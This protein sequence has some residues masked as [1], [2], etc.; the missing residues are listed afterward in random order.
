MAN[1][2]IFPV[3]NV[4]GDTAMSNLLGMAKT[5]Q[6][7]R[8]GDAFLLAVAAIAGCAV[9]RPYPDDDSIDWTLSCKLPK[10]PKID[11]QIKTWTGD[12]GLSKAIRY[13]LKR[14]NYDDLTLEVVAPRLLVLVTIPVEVADWMEL[15]MQQLVMR[16]CVYWISLAG[17]LPTD[18]DTSVTVSVP[19]ENRLTPEALCGMMQRISDGGGI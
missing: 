3:A 14:K 8:F 15:S 2:M 19:R 16:R 13:P 10:R 1:G 11:V 17:L 9:A 4:S 7:E 18:N 6:Q 5:A 12:D